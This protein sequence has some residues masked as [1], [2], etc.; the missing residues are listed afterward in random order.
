PKVSIIDWWRSGAMV[1]LN[2]PYPLYPRP[3]PEDED[4]DDEEE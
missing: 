1:Y 2:K 4:E 3:E